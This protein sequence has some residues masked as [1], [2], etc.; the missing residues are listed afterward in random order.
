MKEIRADDKD[1]RR[2]NRFK[3]SNIGFGY[4]GMG[5]HLN[6]KIIEEEGNNTDKCHSVVI[7]PR[8]GISI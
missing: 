7:S 3:F 1:V 8:E 4:I 5:Y 2:S 6:S